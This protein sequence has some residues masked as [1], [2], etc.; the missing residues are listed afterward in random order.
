MLEDDVDWDIRIKELMQKFAKAS[1]LLVQP[2]AGTENEH[3]DPSWPDG[4]R[5]GEP[6]DLY[7]DKH[8]VRQ[9]TTSPYG[10][11]ERWDMLSVGH[12]GTHFPESRD[13]VP[14]GRA[15]ILDDETVPEPQHVEMQF[16]D[17]VLISEYPPHTR[18]VSRSHGSVCSLGYALS[19]AGAR[20][21]LHTLSLVHLWGAT[22]VDILA[23][24]DGSP[25]YNV[26][27]HVCL[28]PQP[29][30]FQH[31]RPAGVMASFSDISP[32]AD[33]LNE[34]P[35]TRNVRWSTRLNMHKLLYGETDYIDLFQDGKPAFDYGWG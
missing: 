33:R 12:C 22:D 13:G 25:E 32:H 35:F 6:M 24:C 26:P 27:A 7:I 29:Q 1:Q 8:K 31:H 11:L 3:C 4:K 9:P 34:Q 30:I 10:D 19:L 20:R 28:A 21:F 2:L 18:V 23:Y 15:V 17:H 14:L 16:G 5:G